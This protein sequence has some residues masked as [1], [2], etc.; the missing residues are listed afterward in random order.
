MKPTWRAWKKQ[1]S[2]EK[3]RSRPYQWLMEGPASCE[4]ILE[5]ELY[6]YFAGCSYFQLHSDPRIAEAAVR[7]LRDY[8]SGAA[9]T[10][11]MTGTTP[12]VRELENELAACFGTEDAVYL[13]SGY[14]SSMAGMRALMTFRPFDHIFIDEHAHYSVFDAARATGLEVD[15]YRYRD[16]DDL[17]EKL[18]TRLKAGERPLL[19][20]DGLF[21]VSGAL[22]PL[23]V[24][25]ELCEKHDGLLWVDD[26]HGAGI[27]GERGRGSCEALGLN[28]DRIYQ[29][30]T[31]SKAFGAYGGF[32]TGT[33]EYIRTVAKGPV[34]TGSSAPASAAIAAALQGLEILEQEPARRQRLWANARYL[35][36][37]LQ[38]S[39][40]SLEDRENVPGEQ[41]VPI[42]A[43]EAGS[44]EE[45][46]AVRD[47]LMEDGIFIQHTAYQGAGQDGL[48]RIVVSSEHSREQMDRL[49]ASLEAALQ[50]V[51]AGQ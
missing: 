19:A 2:P 50:K 46:A 36:G 44:A 13:P 29:G 12:L 31:L 25:L 49:L 9:T 26:A 45:M 17:A 20:T 18:A 6:L 42:M 40:I 51:G 16:R 10:R 22:A 8:G 35:E 4:V 41:D 11:R 24:L 38:E 43:F 37:K 48:L 21:P 1:R 32:I 27:L 7:A 39:G 30:A 3:M 34:M 15:A 14:L 33:K 47:L 5:G 28:S 23:P